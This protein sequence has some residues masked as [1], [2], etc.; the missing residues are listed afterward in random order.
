VEPVTR[1]ETLLAR[2][3]AALH[4][5]AGAD[6]PPPGRKPALPDPGT[7]QGGAALFRERFESAG[8]TFLE[9][10]AHEAVLPVLGETLRMAGITALIYPADDE[11]AV[12]L[13][14]A[15]VP[16]GPFRIVSGEEL[17]RA[18][19][20]STAGI[21]TAEF[22]IAES[23]TIVQTSRGGKTLL[24]G[25]LTDFHV[26]LVPS[27]IVIDT[28]EECLRALSEDPPRNISFIT[29]PSRTADIELTLT[30]GVHGPRGV[31]A[32]LLP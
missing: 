8:G 32:V 26:A 31:I 19:P 23:G 10:P 7:A 29:G 11:G 28:P 21:Q 20:P 30:I 18:D 6:L 5:H 12:R 13:G 27:G 25:L 3:R 1:K 24:P 9:A 2:V 15:L 22:A 17:R 16:L 14:E 4:R